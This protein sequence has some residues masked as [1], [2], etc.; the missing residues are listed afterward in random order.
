[1]ADAV[2]HHRTEYT[3]A[4]V[5]PFQ[6]EDLESCRLPFSGTYHGYFFVLKFLNLEPV[7]PGTRL[8]AEQL[9]KLLKDLS[10][11]FKCKSIRDFEGEKK[12]VL[13][14]LIA[15]FLEIS[16]DHDKCRTTGDSVEFVQSVGMLDLLAYLYY[17]LKCIEKWLGVKAKL[18]QP[19]TLSS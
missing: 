14:E 12:N 10:P 11:L 18:P 2:N 3:S 5:R 13:S 8:Y 1:M 9:D 6:S 16:S 15:M 17:D 7:K 4:L 19:P